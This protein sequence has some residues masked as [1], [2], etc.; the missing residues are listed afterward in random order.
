MEQT[1]I[2]KSVLQPSN[3]SNTF[4]A[5]KPRGA[6]G[7]T[8]SKGVSQH[9]QDVFQQYVEATKSIEEPEVTTEPALVENSFPPSNHGVAT[10]IYEQPELKSKTADVKTETINVLFIEKHRYVYFNW[11]DD[12]Y[13]IDWYKV[14]PVERHAG[15]LSEQEFLPTPLLVP[16]RLKLAPEEIVWCESQLD[17][18]QAFGFEGKL[19]GQFLIIKQVPNLLRQA[20]NNHTLPR[21]FNNLMALDELT[22]IS[23]QNALTESPDEPVCKQQVLNWFEQPPNHT[24]NLIEKF[25]LRLSGAKLLKLLTEKNF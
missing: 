23:I 6:A 12:L 10:P 8:L 24:E 16:V 9:Q 15:S 13:L 11:R 5:L 1:Q 3:D 7:F 14:S 22:A 18:L 2:S 21:I 19:H 4:S 25:G 17:T 20:S